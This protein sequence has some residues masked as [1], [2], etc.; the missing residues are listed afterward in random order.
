MLVEEQEFELGGAL[1]ASVDVVLANLPYNIR[2][3]WDDENSIQEIFLSAD[4]KVMSKH[5]SE[6]L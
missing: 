5:C 6:M 4:M 3:V 1:Q 2:R